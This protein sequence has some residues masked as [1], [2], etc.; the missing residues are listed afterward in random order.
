MLDQHGQD[1]RKDVKV[2]SFSRPAELLAEL[3]E[4][5]CFGHLPT[6]LPR[7]IKPF[8]LVI[9]WC[10]ELPLD[11]LVCN[12]SRGTFPIRKERS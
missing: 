2:S 7:G 11:C 5:K 6:Y 8:T 12:M 9:V 1:H 10:Y 4:G 3:K